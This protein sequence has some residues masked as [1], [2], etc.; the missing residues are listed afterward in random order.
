MG[1]NGFWA[2]AGADIAKATIHPRPNVVMATE[3]V[4][5]ELASSNCGL[6]SA[7][8]VRG[9][10]LVRFLI[11]GPSGGPD[12]DL[13]VLG[14]ELAFSALVFADEVEGRSA[15]SRWQCGGRRRFG[16]IWLWG[17][18]LELGQQGGIR[19]RR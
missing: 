18:H 16:E 4:P 14:K 6:G 10:L 2:D 15:N 9:V 8:L 3:S 17:A 5:S 12:E 1:S 7:G 19:I 11:I 13:K